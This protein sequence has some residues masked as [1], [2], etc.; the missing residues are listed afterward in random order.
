MEW[1]PGGSRKSWAPSLGTP[2]GQKGL[3]CGWWGPSPCPHIWRSSKRRGG[4]LHGIEIVAIVGHEWDDSCDCRVYK[5]E[6]KQGGQGW[7]PVSTLSRSMH[8]G[9]VREYH[10]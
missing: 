8:G 9:L 1:S 3:S 10:A 4:D 2:L 5:V 6:W 7:M